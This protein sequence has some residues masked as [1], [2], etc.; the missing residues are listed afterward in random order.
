MAPAGREPHLWWRGC[1]MARTITTDDETRQELVAELAWEIG[2]Q[3]RARAEVMEGTVVLSGRVDTTEER[4][5]AVDAA[6]RVP[7][8]LDVVN[9]LGVV[10]SGTPVAADLVLAHEVRRA[11]EWDSFAPDEKIHTTIRG[12]WVTLTG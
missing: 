6:H 9:A 10:V 11:L 7:G 3:S 12:G 1:T 4:R 5:H 8:V 2:R